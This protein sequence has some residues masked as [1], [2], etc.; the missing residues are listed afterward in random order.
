MVTTPL[1][2]TEII[3]SSPSV[4]SA[5]ERLVAAANDAGG[6]DNIGV[7]LVRAYS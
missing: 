4:E 3:Q 5:C 6:E 1:E 2:L 7:V